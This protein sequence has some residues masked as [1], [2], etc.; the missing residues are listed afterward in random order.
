[1]KVEPLILNFGFCIILWLSMKMGL[2]IIAFKVELALPR[3]GSIWPHYLSSL[4]K[5]RRKKADQIWG[6]FWPGMEFDLHGPFS[7]S[8]LPGYFVLFLSFPCIVP[9]LYLLFHYQIISQPLSPTPGAQPERMY[10]IVLAGD[11]A[12]N[13][14]YNVFVLRNKFIRMVEIYK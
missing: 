12:L 5:E 13:C 3:A 2:C 10:K 1:M 14:L 9:N 7:G 11:A 4:R 6:Q 8:R